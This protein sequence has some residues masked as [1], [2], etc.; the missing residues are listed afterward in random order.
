MTDNFTRQVIIFTICNT[1]GA[2]PNVV[3]ALDRIEL[4][5][6]DWEQVFSRLEAMFDVQIDLLTSTDRS[7]SI[8]LLTHS[9]QSVSKIT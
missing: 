1:T 8:E 2:S 3:T 9:L 7:F 4:N 5:T 6:R